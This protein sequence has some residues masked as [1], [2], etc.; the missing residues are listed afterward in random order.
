MRLLLKIYQQILRAYPASYRDKYERQMLETAEDM[1]ADARTPYQ[2]ITVFVRLAID[3]PVSVTK[4]QFASVGGIMTNQTPTYVKQS[5]LVSGAL[6][7]PFFVLIVV[8]A[9]THIFTVATDPWKTVLYI[10]VFFLPVAALML[11]VI[12]FVAWIQDRHTHGVRVATSLHDIAH[13]WPMITTLLIALVIVGF[14]FGHDSVHC[15]AGN[16]IKTVRNTHQTMEC[17]SRG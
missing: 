7:L 3:T 16:P 17:I 1:L 12:T 9:L 15:V 6:L 11:S 8:N 5:S 2:K 13:G 10:S 4:Q 14:A